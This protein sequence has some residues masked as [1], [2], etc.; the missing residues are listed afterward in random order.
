MVEAESAALV[1]IWVLGDQVEPIV[2]RLPGQSS[3]HDGLHLANSHDPVRR[4]QLATLID[5][6]SINST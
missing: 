4:E 1:D 2:L 5:R 6:N 3:F